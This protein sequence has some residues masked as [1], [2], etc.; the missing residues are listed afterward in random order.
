MPLVHWGIHP[1]LFVSRWCALAQAHH[2]RPWDPGP[3]LLALLPPLPQTTATNSSSTCVPAEL[4]RSAVAMP[5][6]A[7]PDPCG[8]HW[9]P[10]S[11]KNSNQGAA[12]GCVALLL[13]DTIGATLRA[14]LCNCN[15]CANETLDLKNHPAA[16]VHS[17]CTLNNHAP[18]HHQTD[19][20]AEARHRPRV[21]FFVD[22]GAAGMT[23]WPRAC[24]VW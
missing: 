5:P 19:E 12:A 24:R 3:A 16:L 11:L 7:Q 8:T 4:L 13:A 18:E 21:S 17:T 9:W 15:V 1:L 23:G 22:V 20:A 14:S 6:C 2:P 10:P